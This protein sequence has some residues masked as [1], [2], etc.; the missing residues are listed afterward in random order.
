MAFF[1]K[2]AV[3]SGC[4][5]HVRRVAHNPTTF[6]GRVAYNPTFTRL[7]RIVFRYKAQATPLA[8]VEHFLGNILEL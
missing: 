5:Q 1:H 3:C 2:T 7:L 4:E 6:V 8:F